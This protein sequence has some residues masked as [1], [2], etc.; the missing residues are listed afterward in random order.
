MPKPR[1]PTC[2]RKADRAKCARRRAAGHALPKV[3]GMTIWALGDRDNWRCHLC[4]KRVDPRIKAPD[5]RCPSFD[6]L[7]PVSDGGT[8]ARSNVKLAHLGCN[9]RRGAGGTVQL[10]LVG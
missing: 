2:V 4:R 10:M 7:D 6:H 9:S 1:C 8:D 3:E 5:R